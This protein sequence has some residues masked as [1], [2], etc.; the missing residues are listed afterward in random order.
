MPLELLKPT[1]LGGPAPWWCLQLQTELCD[2]IPNA[3]FRLANNRVSYTQP[4]AGYRRLSGTPVHPEQ[5]HVCS[6]RCGK[7]AY[8]PTS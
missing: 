6:P 8:D 4:E 7:A 1:N 2:V 5:I 3:L